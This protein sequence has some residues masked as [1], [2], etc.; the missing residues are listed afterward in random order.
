MFVGGR[1]CY[2]FLF[3]AD[4][5]LIQGSESDEEGE[6]KSSSAEEGELN[7]GEENSEVRIL[8][9]VVGPCAI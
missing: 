5:L 1:H 2:L 7:D 3:Y 9:I 6:I 8:F 4:V